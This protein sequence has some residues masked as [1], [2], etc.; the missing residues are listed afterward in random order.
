MAFYRLR[1]DIFTSEVPITGNLSCNLNK[2]MNK[3]DERNI[4][5]NDVYISLLYGINSIIF[6]SSNRHDLCAY[7]C[8][9]KHLYLLYA[10][11]HTYKL[12]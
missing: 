2:I 5:P 8:G 6:I 11:A 9:R 4:W 12:R 7:L 10:I 1:D 3:H